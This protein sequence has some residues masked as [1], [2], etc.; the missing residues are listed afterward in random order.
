MIILRTTRLEPVRDD[1][2]TSDDAV[3]GAVT[4]DAGP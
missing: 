3:G 4:G 2:D 1:A